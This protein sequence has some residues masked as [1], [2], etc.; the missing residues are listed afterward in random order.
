MS[1]YSSHLRAGVKQAGERTVQ[2]LP[3]YPRRRGGALNR[4]RPRC[5]APTEWHGA[6]RPG[7]RAL[8]GMESQGRAGLGPAPTDLIRLASPGTCPY[9]FCPC[10]TVPPDR[11]NRPKGEG[12]RAAKGRPYGFT[13]AGEALGGRVRT[14]A[15]TAENGLGALAGK[16]RRSPRTAAILNFAHPGPQWARKET[17]ASTHDFARRK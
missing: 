6:A 1:G 9:P 12:L 14:P 4:G 7:G 3:E 8:H 16:L 15:P 17:Q 10:G 13:G 11:G 2:T 5:A